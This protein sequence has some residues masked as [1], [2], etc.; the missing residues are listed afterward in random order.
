[1]APW[2]TL[3]QALVGLDDPDP[4]Y[5]E[6]SPSKKRFLKNYRDIDCLKVGGRRITILRPDILAMKGGVSPK[7]DASWPN[8]ASATPSPPTI[9][10]N[11][12]VLSGC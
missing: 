12:P 4:A 11:K 6:L 2:V 8:T 1:M 5:N 3:R 9:T 10:S 7:P